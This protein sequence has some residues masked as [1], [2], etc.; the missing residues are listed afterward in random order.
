M[1]VLF[2]NPNVMWVVLATFAALAAGTV[3]RLAAV[4]RAAKDVAKS[5]LDSLRTWWIVAI[6]VVAGALLGRTA[7]AL[8]FAVVSL[9]S[10]REFARLPENDSIDKRILVAAYVL[11]PLSYLWIWLGWSQVFV[12]FLPLTVVAGSS[13]LLVTAERVSHYVFNMGRMCFGIMLTAYFL[14]HVVLLFNLPPESNPVAGAAGW[15]LFVV[16]LTEGNDILQ[17]LIGRSIG[18]RKITPRVSPNKTWEG[19][20]GALAI[21][22][23]VASVLGQLLTPLSILESAAGGLLIALAG[24]FGDLNMSAVKRDAGV[25]D[26]SR[27]LPGQGGILD[28]VDSLTFSAPVFYYF[29]VLVV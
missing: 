20:L 27:L 26:S 6:V 7:T 2:L 29:V 19:F 15:F 28:R 16:M 14:G 24:F 11:I 17:A 13:I 18:R 3:V 12:A 25:K 23:L 8:V 1:A 9:L 4:R 10:M 5:R 22:T 21:T